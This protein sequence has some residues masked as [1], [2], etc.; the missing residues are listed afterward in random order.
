[1]ETTKKK[2][3]ITRKEERRGNRGG[4]ISEQKSTKETKHLKKNQE[5][6]Q[7]I[8]TE[9]NNNKTLKF[10]PRNESKRPTKGRYNTRRQPSIKC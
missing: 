8:A 4:G 2:N 5:R 3:G 6:L 1:L 9:H 7:A 10:T